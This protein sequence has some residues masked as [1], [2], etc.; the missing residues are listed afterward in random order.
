MLTGKEHFYSEWLEMVRSVVKDGP[1][2]D[3]GTPR[4]FQKEMAV[5]RDVSASPVFCADYV[6]SPDVDL[7]ADAHELPFADGSI[8]GL[9]C[10]HVLEH[11][12]DPY[13][14]VQEV[15][16]I[17]KPGGL[18]YFTVLDFWP[19]HANPGVYPDYHRFKPDAI[20][21]LFSDWRS[22][23]TLR[24]GG[25]AQI[26]TTYLPNRIRPLG[27]WVANRFDKRYPT[28]MTPIVYV[29]AEA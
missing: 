2:L 20:D 9:L 21:L 22:V 6:P 12:R 5:V 11:V 18:A 14:V 23:R 17:M 27:Q 3:L 13:S 1:I 19:Y 26:I 25:V 10:S 29:L 7:L 4:P 15:R 24:G 8:G 16:R 28:T